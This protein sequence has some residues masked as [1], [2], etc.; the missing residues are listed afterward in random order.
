MQI[1][2][3]LILTRGGNRYVRVALRECLQEVDLSKLN[4][5]AAH[6]SNLMWT[7]IMAATV[8]HQNMAAVRGVVQ[9]R[10]LGNG[11][12]GRLCLQPCLPVCCE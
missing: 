10:M 1:K 6:C 5:F 12:C 7:T 2:G 3:G 9:W 4:G 8:R 11:T